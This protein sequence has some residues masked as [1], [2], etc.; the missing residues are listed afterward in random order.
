MILNFRQIYF[1][2]FLLYYYIY[3]RLLHFG[4]NNYLDY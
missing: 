3:K 2:F 4:S 1:Q